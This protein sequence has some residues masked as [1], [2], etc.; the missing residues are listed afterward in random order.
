MVVKTAVTGMGI[1]LIL[2]LA[3]W[4][5]LR[6]HCSAFAQDIKY[7]A[8]PDASKNMTLLLKDFDP[9]PMLHVPVHGIARAK[10]PVIDVHNHVNDPGGIHGEEIPAA[11]V[12]RR[13]DQMNVQKIVIL[14]GQ[15]G[16]KLQGLIDK[17][18]KPYPER[19]VVF[20]Q[21]DYKDID[22]PGFTAKQVAQLDDAVRRGARGLKVLKDLGLGDR[23]K[24]GKLITIDDPRLDA[25]WEECGRL[26]IPVAIHTSDPEAFFTPVDNHNERY[27]E[28]HENPSWSFYGPGIPS[29]EELLRQRNHV[30]EKHP[31]TTFIALHVAN[32][33]ENLDT[34]SSWLDKY[35][36]MLVEF[37]ARQ[38]ELGRQPRRAGRFFREYQDRILFGTDS[39]PETAMYANYFRWLETAD[40]Y[41]PYWGYPGQGRWEIYGLE[42]PDSILEKVYHKNADRMF[43]QFKGAR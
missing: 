38:A 4:L 43:A 8:D 39:E 36:N 25:I 21:I 29:K 37:G 33:P 13:M 40:E 5:G 15:W 6:A 12:V 14:T 16:E 2:S 34:V 31:R 9:K 19:F 11:E 32:W 26:G 24:Q 18:V 35:P 20:T 23:D 3:L 10:F 41:F 1:R 27:E 30:F 22:E 7:A 17:M 28:L 42:L